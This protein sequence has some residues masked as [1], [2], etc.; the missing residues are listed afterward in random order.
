M[1][2]RQAMN[3][4]R[5][6]AF[7][8]ASLLGTVAAAQDRQTPASK[9]SGGPFRIVGY[10]PD[11]RLKTFDESAARL[12][13]DLVV[14]SAEAE[15]SGRLD[16]K[17]LPPEQLRRLKQI[18]QRTRVSLI[19]CIGGW[20]RSNGFATLSASSEARGRLVK[21]ATRCCLDQRFDGV[22]LDWEHPVNDTEQQNYAQLLADLKAGFQEHGLTVSVTMAAWQHLPREAY[23][24]VDSVQIMAY[25]NDGQ[26]STFNAAKRDVQAL[27]ERGAPVEKIVLGLPFYGRGIKDRNQTLTYAEIVQKHSPGPEV[28]EVA[29]VYFNGLRMIEKKVQFAKSSKLSGVMIWELGQDVPGE[30]SLL[31]TIHR[32]SLPSVSQ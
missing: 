27:L 15:P 32:L 16:T 25:D 2:F 7:F 4:P 26:H 29:G 9:E 28:D 13:T 30:T 20:G 19:L 10:L 14:F 3:H 31:K 12:V 22:D 17:R 5:I 24:T 6:A 11:Y 8:L 1:I 18:K 23:A 21:E